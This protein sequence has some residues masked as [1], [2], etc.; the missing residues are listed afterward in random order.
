MSSA[1]SSSSSSSSGATE[2]KGTVMGVEHSWAPH[3]AEVANLFA[4]KK[5]GIRYLPELKPALKIT[6]EAGRAK[7]PY[8]RGKDIEF[9]LTELR[10]RHPI[11]LKAVTNLIQKSDKQY[12]VDAAKV[13][14]L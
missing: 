5:G 8:F 14:P 13:R 11:Y 6:A 3:V 4:R 2:R 9:T 7:V 1:S 10:T 12:Y